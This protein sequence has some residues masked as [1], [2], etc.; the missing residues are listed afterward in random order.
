MLLV[1]FFLCLA[2]SLAYT[3]APWDDESWFATPGWNLI[4]QGHMGT[5]A[6]DPTA[7]F[8]SGGSDTLNHKGVPLTGI[9]R[10][11]YWVMPLHFVATAAW[12][13]VFGFSLHSLRAFTISWALLA[14]LCWFS[15]VLM[16]FWKPFRKLKFLIVDRMTEREFN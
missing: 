16:N 3:L 7:T 1:G 13:K 9:D 12:Y 4:S 11:T 10:H 5:S 6:L 14:L 8:S 2:G 15:I